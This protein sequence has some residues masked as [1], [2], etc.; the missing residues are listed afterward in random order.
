MVAVWNQKI[1]P[2]GPTGG[3]PM[4]EVIVNGRRAWSYYRYP[5]KN[6][7]ASFPA[8]LPSRDYNT[9]WNAMSFYYTE[10]KGHPTFDM[11]ANGFT[12]GNPEVPGFTFNSTN[13]VLPTLASAPKVGVE[14]PGIPFTD[15]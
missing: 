14:V 13:A 6:P 5:S 2:W 12:L 7:V 9:A 4:V 10:T 3:N 15:P 11:N 1:D 8:G